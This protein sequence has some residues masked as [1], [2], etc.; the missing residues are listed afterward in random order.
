M[1]TPRFFQVFD[2]D[3]APAAV[4]SGSRHFAFGPFQLDLE[5]HTLS[6]GDN[7]LALPPKCFDLLCILVQSK[8]E[9]LEKNR[10][11]QQLWPDTYVEEANLSNLIALLRK[12]LGDSPSNSQY[13]Q[14]VPKLGYRFK[15]AVDREPGNA[16]PR[17][18]PAIAPSSVLRIIVFPF[19]V[20]PDLNELEHL[21]YSLPESIS[22]S[23]SELNAFAVRAMQVAMRFDPV[24]WE[25]RQVAK[26]ADVD[27]IITGTLARSETGLQAAVQLMRAAS[28]TL[29]WSKSWNIE[30]HEI[31]SLHRAVVQHTVDSLVKSCSEPQSAQDSGMPGQSEAF[32]AYLLANQLSLKRTPDNMRLARDLYL[33]CVEKDPDFAPAWA[34]LGRCYHFLY[35]LGSREERNPDLS[36]AAFHRAFAIQP[37]LVLAH[38]LCTPVQ[39]DLGEAQQAMVRLLTALQTH[40]NSPE[41]LAGLVHACRYCGQLEASLAAHKR[42]IEVDPNARTSVAHSFFA[43]GDYERALFW[44]G[45]GAGLYLDAL[46]LACMGR[47]REAQTLLWSRREQFHLMSG[48]MASL[49]AWLGNDRAKGVAALETALKN[50]HPEPELQFYMGRQASVFGATSLA[51]AFL[52]RA[53]EAG[54]WSSYCMQADPW[55]AGARNTPEFQSILETARRHEAEARSAFVDCRG[56]WLLSL[57]PA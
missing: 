21:G 13:V 50:D 30:T 19:R 33:S 40:P 8:G 56:E 36:A 10:L 34:R 7:A 45:T 9:L 29:L 25:P 41:L 26:E 6:R 2:Q 18:S 15:A 24:R 31:I 32:N 53:V 12:A 14:T 27:Y 38:S 4:P 42:A 44:Y 47:N 46:A 55:F 3:L 35:K 57:L 11:M 49:D 28:G 5:K 39:A 52:R 37:D 20:R 43:K 17:L 51:N 54:Y 1:E 16:A 48:A 22:S 23:L